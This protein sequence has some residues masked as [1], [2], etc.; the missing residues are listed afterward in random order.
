MNEDRYS[1]PTSKTTHHQHGESSSRKRL[2][3]EEDVEN[4][5]TIEKL[6]WN[7]RHEREE[8]RKKGYLAKL[9]PFDPK[10]YSNTLTNVFKIF[11]AFI[12]LYFFI[13]QYW[14]VFFMWSTEYG[15]TNALIIYCYLMIIVLIVI[16]HTHIHTSNTN[17]TPIFSFT[18]HIQNF[19]FAQ[20]M[21]AV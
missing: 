13:F 21:R 17:Y 14:A 16:I 11:G 4:L 10:M 15:T 12:I 2:I 7:A 19:F 20:L 6:Q 8:H 3:P 1:S 5:K 9:A 18:N